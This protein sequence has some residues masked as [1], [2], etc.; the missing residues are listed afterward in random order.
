[1]DEA[2]LVRLAQG[3]DDA[4]G[5]AKEALHF[6]RIADQSLERFAARILEQQRRSTAFAGK[7]ERPRRPCGFELVPQFIL[8][9]EAI[10][11]SRDRTLRGRLHRQRRAAAARA[12][13]APP[14]VEDAFAVL[15][16]ELEIAKPISVELKGR[17]HLPDSAAPPRSDFCTR[18]PATLPLNEP[19]SKLGRRKKEGPLT[20]RQ[21][22]RLANF[23]TKPTAL[24][25]SQN[26]PAEVSASNAFA[27]VC[28]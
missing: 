20:A 19:R 17:V 18:C 15:P 12:V 25:R 16:Q 7:R 3:C 2:A 9:S 28:R 26:L 5:K 14:A 21:A 22:P 1:V 8:V 10:E 6:H 23:L 24:R 13:C 4:D 11:G 27:V